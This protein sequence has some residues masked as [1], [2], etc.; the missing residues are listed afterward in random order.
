MKFTFRIGDRPL[1]GF[2]LK[3]GVSHGGFGEVYFGISE[4]G[5]EVALKCIRRNL[6]VEL[7]GIQPC[8]N[9]KHPHLVHLYDLRRDEQHNVW[10][11]MEYVSGE[12]LDGILQRHPHGVGQDLATE[13]FLGLASAVH[14]LHDHGIVHRDLKPANIFLE[15]GTVKVGD[16]GLCKAIGT[17]QHVAQTQNVGTVHYMAPEISRGEY[18]RRVDIYAAGI[19]LYEML[20]GHPPFDGDSAG[21]ILYKHV[22][23]DPD[24]SAAPAGFKPILAKAL[25]KDPRERYATIAA[26]ANDV[27]ALRTPQGTMHGT[28][29]PARVTEVAPRLASQMPTREAAPTTVFPGPGSERIREM[30]LASIIAV[31]VAAGWGMLFQG[32]D[33]RSVASAA[34]LGIVGSC[35]LILAKTWWRRPREESWRR[36]L[37]LGTFGVLLGVAAV[38]LQGYS[39]VE[40]TRPSFVVAGETTPRHPFFSALYSDSP[41]LPVAAAYA[42]YF[43]LIFLLLR[44]WKNVEPT[45]EE[46]FSFP[47][48]GAVLFWAYVLLFLLPGTEERRTAFVA[49]AATAVATQCASPR[50][51]PDPEPSK[52]LRLK[53]V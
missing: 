39:I 51:E 10:L 22:L 33:W 4:G 38:W 15:N 41:K 53:N 18:D 31:A 30:L 13:W 40:A 24:L 46:R 47:A 45:R 52:R 23:D 49:L 6:D 9:L 35:G 43:G 42:A 17:S 14:Y 19:I 16:Y 28:P 2:V 20:T 27:A 1:P 7:R 3:R 25:T 44:W 48:L 11:V 34:L 8:L 21:E 37:G 12:T 32:G 36:R 26:M 5:K 29:A 50:R